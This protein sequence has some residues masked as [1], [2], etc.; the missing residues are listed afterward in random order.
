MALSLIK[1]C[2]AM[3]A[4]QE[5]PLSLHHLA[6]AMTQKAIADHLGCDAS[7]ISRLRSGDQQIGRS[8]LL[9][10]RLGELASK[11]GCHFI[12]EAHGDGITAI[13]HAQISTD[14]CLLDEMREAVEAIGEASQCYGAGA[15]CRGLRAVARL[16]RA[17][18]GMRAEFNLRLMERAA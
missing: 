5:I 17:A 2:M 13:E 8:Y 4:T 15:I 9:G 11:H 14:G 3:T 7:L 12:A 1:P 6:A 10:R 16:I 18:I